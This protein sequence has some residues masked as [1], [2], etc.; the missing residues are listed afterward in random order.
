MEVSP[1]TT[2]PASP[3]VPP[4]SQL[5]QMESIWRSDGR[6]MSAP[7][8]APLPGRRRWAAEG[9]RPASAASS[10]TASARRWPPGLSPPGRRGHVCEDAV[11][12]VGVV[13]DAELV[14]HGGWQ[15][16][17]GCYRL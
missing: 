17:G 2:A 3:P 1:G 4:A 12:D 6:G 7:A 16:V 8:A 9:Q 5:S 15:R 10:P 13:V 14:G 11:D